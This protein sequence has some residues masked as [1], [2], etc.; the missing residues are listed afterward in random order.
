MYS[1]AEGEICEPEDVEASSRLLEVN[2]ARRKTIDERQVRGGNQRSRKAWIQRQTDEQF[3]D[4]PVSRG[5]SLRLDVR[6][7]TAQHRFVE[8]AELYERAE[9]TPLE[10]VAAPLPQRIDRGEAFA[11]EGATLTMC[12]SFAEPKDNV[13]QKGVTIRKVIV[14]QRFAHPCALRDCR[15]RRTVHA[16]MRHDAKG[17][18]NDPVACGRRPL[19]SHASA[20]GEITPLRA[21]DRSAA[22]TRR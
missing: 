6:G 9:L 5:Q 14:Q 15:H 19:V 4:R 11:I 1:V 13:T 17:G 3:A 7:R 12:R 16:A 18:P 22:R 20:H 10:L 2:S 21:G 8:K